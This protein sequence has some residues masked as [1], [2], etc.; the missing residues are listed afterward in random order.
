MI[1]H[2][3]LLLRRECRTSIIF[4]WTKKATKWYLPVWS[5]R[6]VASFCVVPLRIQ[7]SGGYCCCR[8][9]CCCCCCC[10][11]NPDSSSC[12]HEAVQ[13][14]WSLHPRLLLF[15]CFGKHHLWYRVHRGA[16]EFI[17]NVSF[18]FGGA[19]WHFKWRTSIETEFQRIVH[20]FFTR[21]NTLLWNWWIIEGKWKRM[22]C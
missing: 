4:M 2:I 17:Q 22:G 1:N 8:C 19:H 18:T 20:S 15:L 6:I 5:R 21:A 16:N 7:T 14:V 13:C 10:K 9:N 11:W 12:L 3:P